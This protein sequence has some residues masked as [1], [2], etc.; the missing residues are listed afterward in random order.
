M[1]R[2]NSIS[3]RDKI[4]PHLQYASYVARHKWF[5]FRAG[6]QTRAPLWRLAIHDWSKLSVGEW[7]PYVHSFYGPGD[8]KLKAINDAFDAAW[9]HHQHR[10]PHHWQHWLLQE[11]DGVL[12]VLEMPE[13][14]VREMVADW[15]GAGRAITGKWDTVGW[16]EKNCHKIKLAPKTRELTEQLLGYAKTH[17]FASGGRLR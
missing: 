6:L 14:F 13:K 1:P 9:L 16:Y 4:K 5:V 12:K 8:R 3:L 11:D 17:T 10:N 2:T 7:S 15:M